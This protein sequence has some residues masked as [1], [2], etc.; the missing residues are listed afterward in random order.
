MSE[1]KQND[2]IINLNN[3][4]DEVCTGDLTGLVKNPD[5]DFTRRR[6]LPL[7]EFL[8]VTLNM[9]GG[10]IRKE[11]YRAFPVKSERMTAT[12]YEK[13]K[14]KVCPEMF[15][16]ILHRYNDTIEEPKLLKDK[17]RLYAIDGS[18]FNPIYSE[19]SEFVTVQKGGKKRSDGKDNEPY[20]QIHANLLYDLENHYYYDCITQPKSKA[21][22]RDA[23]IEMIKNIHCDE[24][25]IVTMDRGYDG[26]NIMENCNRIDN[27]YF[28]IRTKAGR[29]GIREVAN[30]PDKP[31]DVWIDV[32]ITSSGQYY[33]LWHDT[34]PDL[35]LIQ[36]P[37]KP[38]TTK[39]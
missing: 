6:K 28:V 11:L 14:D 10:S 39:Y 25:F 13:A 9:Q 32:R 8:K 29:G 37:K 3:I 24:P 2:S 19:D 5:T 1:G 33:K 36:C 18:D 16:E 27:C 21:N 17:Y 12:A 35:H 34:E 22:E 38:H 4:I 23:A 30:L 26:F 7:D 20:C 15:R 31:C